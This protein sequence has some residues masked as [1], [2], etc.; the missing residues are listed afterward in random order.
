MLAIANDPGVDMKKLQPLLDD[1]A[2]CMITNMTKGF[3]DGGFFAE[4][5]G[6]GSMS[7]HIAFLPGLQAWKTAG[8]KD[9]LSPRPNAQWMALKWIFLTVPNSKDKGNLNGS[10]PQRGAYPHNIWDRTGLSGAGYFSEGFGAVNNEYKP[11]LLWFYNHHLKDIDEQAAAPLDT[12][13]FYPHHSVLSFVNWP[14][15]LEEKNPGECLPH[16][17]RDS[18]MGG[19]YAWRNRWE[20]EHDTVISILTQ[21]TKG[22]YSCKAETSLTVWSQHKRQSWGKING[23]FKGDFLPRSD[24]SSVLTTGDGSCLAIDFSQA[25]GLDA[26][27]VMTGPGAPSNGA[28]EAGGTKF[29]F[30]L[31]GNNP[32]TPTADGNQVKVGNQ[33]VSFDGKKIALGR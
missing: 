4:G 3:G 32:P 31:L 11:G 26:M 15:T 33:T 10:F 6:T 20:N 30:L 12:V 25:S 13:S 18:L 1:N 22:N 23:G 2:Q 8:G 24:G 29:S 14:L 21:S 27:L 19:F 16:A 28:V 7:S 17:Y 9:F 5:D